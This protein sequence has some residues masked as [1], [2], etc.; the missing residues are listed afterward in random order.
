MKPWRPY[1]KNLEKIENTLLE[2]ANPTPFG[3]FVYAF[4]W[5]GKLP[6]TE[7]VMCDD[8]VEAIIEGITL[9]NEFSDHNGL[10][11]DMEWQLIL[12][13][14]MGLSFCKGRHFKRKEFDWNQSPLKVYN[15]LLKGIWYRDAM[16]WASREFGSDALE[17]SRIEQNINS[18]FWQNSPPKKPQLN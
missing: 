3:N 2:K 9:R 12:R 11:P 16:Y 8:F 13:I 15:W 1:W 4:E 5:I 17:K 6:Y 7:L 18:L 14:D 10:D